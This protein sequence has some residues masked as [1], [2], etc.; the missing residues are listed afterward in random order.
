MHFEGTETFAA[1]PAA[2]FARLADAGWV[3]RALP[4]G[5]LLTVS[6]DAA[7]WKVRP[8]FA[9]MAGSLD[10]T[11]TVS[12]RTPDRSVRYRISSQGIGSRSLME[13]TLSVRPKETSGSIV[14]WTGDLV[15]L[16][17]LLGRVPKAMVQAAAL[18]TIADVWQAVHA[19]VEREV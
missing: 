1:E 10:T 12:Y 15:D 9:F 7:A 11:A 6:A 14:H 2:V 3:A 5:E 13:A 16:G 4:A 19:G 18:R 8:M 17:G